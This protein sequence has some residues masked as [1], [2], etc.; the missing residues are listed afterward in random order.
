MSIAPE[1]QKADD[2]F[3]EADERL[4]CAQAAE[5]EYHHDLWPEQKTCSRWHDVESELKLAWKEYRAA[6]AALC[7]VCPS[8]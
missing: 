5:D 6:W 1:V 4:K 8:D 2:A 7:A 3:N